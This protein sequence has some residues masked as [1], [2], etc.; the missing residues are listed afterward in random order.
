MPVAGI[1]RLA[2]MLGTCSVPSILGVNVSRIVRACAPWFLVCAA[3][4]WG[5]AY[6][7]KPIR[8]VVGFTPGGG[9]D[10]IA[11]LVGGNLSERFRQ[12]VVI[13]NR[14]GAGGMVGT[15]LVAKSAPDGYSLLLT[16]ANFA[17]NP[18]LYEKTVLYDP[19]KDFAAI[20]RLGASQYLLTVTPNLPAASVKE[21][22]ALAKAKPGT[23]NVAS[24][25]IGGPGHL[26]AELFRFLTGAEL[27]HIPYKGTSPAVTAL[28]SGEAQVIFGN[29][30]ATLPLV[31]AGKLK[32]L[33]VS[34]AVRSSMAKEYPTVAE[35]GV[36]GFDVSSWYGVL[37]PA[38]TPPAVIQALS[39]ELAQILEVREMRDKLAAVGLEIWGA[40]PA[41]FAAYINAEIGKWKKVARA[42][43]IR[44]E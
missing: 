16:N 34:G 13:E 42:S 30:G 14:P 44:G 18:A 7:A 12:P 31:Q 15:A 43:G 36:P 26:S 11:R 22:I 25:G 6:P 41:P 23:L 39:K 1:S 21:L 19:V 10:A 32:G 4:A 17:T 27:V 8:L 2:P 20:H 29:V 35:A 37:A 9:A 40:A 28:L 24:A 3:S 5:Q 33:A 38:G